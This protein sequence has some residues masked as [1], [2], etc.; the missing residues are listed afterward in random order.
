MAFAR[1]GLHVFG[2]HLDRKATLV[3][4]E[5][6]AAEVRSLGRGDAELVL[7]SGGTL[8]L[9]RRYRPALSTWLNGG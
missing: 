9:S 4:A 1:A 3:N 7:R 2:V 8:R 6:I 5:R